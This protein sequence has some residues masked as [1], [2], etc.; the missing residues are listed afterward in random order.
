MEKKNYFKVIQIN[1]NKYID[2][3]HQNKSFLQKILALFIL[4]D[5]QFYFPKLHFIFRFFSIL[6]ATYLYSAAS[7]G[8]NK[9]NLFDWLN[10]RSHWPIN[11][12]FLITE[13][14]KVVRWSYNNTVISRH[15]G[16]W[17]V[18][19]HHTTAATTKLRFHP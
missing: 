4:W 17:C 11:P 13:E 19:T 5:K 7:N 6:W 18:R 16:K 1:N 2:W 8:R 3:S 15:D 10:L 9:T 14:E 12:I